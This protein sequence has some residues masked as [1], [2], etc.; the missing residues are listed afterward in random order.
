MYYD[1]Q[2]GMP[3]RPL[4]VTLT[5]TNRESRPKN[6]DLISDVPMEVSVVL[7]KTE[8]PV[9]QIL[10]L[11][12]GAIVELNK[13][14]EEPLDIFVNGMLVGQGEVVVI[15]ER[16]GIRINSILSTKEMAES[17]GTLR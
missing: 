1:P 10:S 4:F 13:Y 5:K 9:R 7:G 3:Q 6:I 11:K 12:P 2:Y 17:V 8:R 15:E 14:A 16:I